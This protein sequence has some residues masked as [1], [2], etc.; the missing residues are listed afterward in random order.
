LNS[1]GLSTTQ[2]DREAA[3]GQDNSETISPSASAGVSV[4]FFVENY[5][6][7]LSQR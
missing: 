4:A 2:P 1:S 5:P 3:A 6:E 7:I